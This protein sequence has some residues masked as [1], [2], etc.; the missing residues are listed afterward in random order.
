MTRPAPNPWIQL[1]HRSD[2]VSRATLDAAA[3]AVTEQV[4]T[5]LAPAWGVGEELVIEVIGRRE[6]PSPQ[7]WWVT[8]VDDPDVADALG[9]HDATVEGLPLCKVFVR[10]T[11]DAGQEL[12]GV[13]SHEICE[14]IV[15]PLVNEWAFDDHGAFWALETSDAV[16]GYDYTI[17]GVTVADFV[18]PSFFFKRDRTPPYDHLGLVGRPFQTMPSGYQIKYS[19]SRGMHQVYGSRR[20]MLLPASWGKPAP[21]VGSRRER[22]MRGPQHWCRST[23]ATCR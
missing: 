10:P 15:D 17:G 12:S 14:A 13:V 23:E 7:A 18:L 1:I 2:L 11:L 19:R 9:F 3:A 20:S 6:K 5:H 21:R 4:R 8:V 22:R 16:Q